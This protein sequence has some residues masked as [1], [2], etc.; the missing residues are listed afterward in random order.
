LL[1]V[2]LT[3]ESLRYGTDVTWVKHLGFWN[4]NDASMSME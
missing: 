2:G 1:A 3:F 4:G